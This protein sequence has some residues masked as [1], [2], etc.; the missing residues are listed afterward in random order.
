MKET[1]EVLLR[2]TAACPDLLALH[3]RG[4]EAVGPRANER[5]F[6]TGEAARVTRNGRTD[7][8][9]GKVQLR[10][11]H[12]GSGDIAS[13]A[14]RHGDGPGVGGF[15]RARGLLAQELFLASRLG[16]ELLELGLL[17]GELRF[18]QSQGDL[19]GRWIDLKE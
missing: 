11:T 8:T 5:A 13:K 18:R 9:I 6:G 12:F 4:Q 2:N 7:F 17:L 16:L 15:L 3:Y 1:S 14:R 19:I 10:A